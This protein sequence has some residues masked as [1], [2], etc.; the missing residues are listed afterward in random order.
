MKDDFS[1]LDLDPRVLTFRADKDSV[2]GWLPTSGQPDRGETASPGT[3]TPA[4]TA[5]A[6]SSHSSL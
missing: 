4:L 5:F 2:H 6:F 3:S 1:G